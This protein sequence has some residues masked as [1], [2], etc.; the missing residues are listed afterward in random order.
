LSTSTDQAEAEQVQIHES[1]RERPQASTDL[2][3][4]LVSGN[5]AF[6]GLQDV[7]IYTT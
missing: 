5:N 4:S 7:C 6:V 2:G 3:Y 1:P